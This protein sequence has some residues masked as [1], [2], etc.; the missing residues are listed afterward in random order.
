MFVAEPTRKGGPHYSITTTSVVITGDRAITRGKAVESD[1][2]RSGDQPLVARTAAGCSPPRLAVHLRASH[3]GGLRRPSGMNIGSVNETELAERFEAQRP[4][5]VRL[6]YGHLGSLAEAEDVV[7][8]AW[9][10]LERVIRARSATCRV[11]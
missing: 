1:G 3:L 4:R 6:A 9:L 2:P 10:R 11:G 8:D 7:Q 5:L